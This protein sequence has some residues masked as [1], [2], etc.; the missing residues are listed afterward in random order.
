M[1]HTIRLLLIALLAA[2]AVSATPH[3][4]RAGRAEAAPT[5]VTAGVGGPAQESWGAAS[6]AL[7]R[8]G[9]FSGWLVP[10]NPM[11]GIAGGACI[12]AFIDIIF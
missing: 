10:G 7:C 2:T 8:A 1:K 5:N 11:F 4:S 6:R 3:S 12:M 9:F